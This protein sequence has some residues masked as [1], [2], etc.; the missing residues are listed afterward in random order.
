MNEERE[1]AQTHL[2]SIDNEESTFA[3][4]ETPRHLVRKVDVSWGINEVQDVL[5]TRA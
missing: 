5:F 2:S 1:K 3:R 4:R